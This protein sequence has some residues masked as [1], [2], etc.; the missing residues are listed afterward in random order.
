[1]NIR[2]ACRVL[3]ITYFDSTHCT[4]NYHSAA[5]YSFTILAKCQTT[6]SLS[7]SREPAYHFPSSSQVRI[8]PPFPLAVF[9]SLD[10]KCNHPILHDRPC[11]PRCLPPRRL[12]GPH[13]AR[14]PPRP[15]MA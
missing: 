9:L 14:P 7:R 15:P 2:P 1:M 12:H 8:S 10:R 11:A 4:S 5:S 6:S 13:L 3:T